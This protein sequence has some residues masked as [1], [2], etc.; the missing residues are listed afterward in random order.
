MEGSLRNFL[1]LARP[2]KLERSTQDLTILVERT[3]ELIRGRASRQSV[4]VRFD[5]PGRP[6]LLDVDGEQLQQ[7]LLNLAL[8]ALDAMPRGGTLTFTL[9]LERAGVVELGVSDSGPGIAPAIQPRLFQPFASDKETGLGLG[10]VVSRRIVEGH[11]GELRAVNRPEGGACFSV[12]L[13]ARPVDEARGRLSVGLVASRS[14][15]ADP[16]GD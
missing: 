15:H 13:P 9:D 12:V 4:R 3:L 10:L 11:D 16:A 14:D 5:R 2:P 6:V 1:D 7:V 8:N